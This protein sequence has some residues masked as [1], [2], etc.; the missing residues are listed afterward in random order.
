MV[1]RLYH[2]VPWLS[3]RIHFAEGEKMFIRKRGAGRPHSA[4]DDMHVNA[5]R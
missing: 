4:S 5:V 3:R 1:Q 2:I